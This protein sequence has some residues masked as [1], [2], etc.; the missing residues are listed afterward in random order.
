VSEAKYV[1]VLHPTRSDPILTAAKCIV[2]QE[3]DAPLGLPTKERMV[4]F[5]QK[6]HAISE[7]FAEQHLGRAADEQTSKRAT[8]KSRPDSTATQE[9]KAKKVAAKLQ[10]KEHKE[11][12]TLL[13]AKQ[14][15]LLFVNHNWVGKDVV[16][17]SNGRTYKIV[18]YHIR[19]PNAGLHTIHSKAVRGPNGCKALTEKV[20]VLVGMQGG[21][22]RID[23]GPVSPS[24]PKEPTTGPVSPSAPKDPSGG[25]EQLVTG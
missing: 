1:G 4:I 7:F 12:R 19:K 20:N 18:S 14:A 9:N 6:Y 25:D 22:I 2:Q 5:K 3:I 17:S 23:D 11:Q 8:K 13:E 10:A 16:C 24:A 15:E 21:S